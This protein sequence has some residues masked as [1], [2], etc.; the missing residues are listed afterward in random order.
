MINYSVCHPAWRSKPATCVA[1]TPTDARTP[2]CRCRRMAFVLSRGRRRC[3]EHREAPPHM[4]QLPLQQSLAL[5]IRCPLRVCAPRG[6][7]AGASRD[8]APHLG[9]TIMKQHL[10]MLVGKCVA[11]ILRSNAQIMKSPQS[12]GN[13][14]EQAGWTLAHHRQTHLGVRPSALLWTHRPSSGSDAKRPS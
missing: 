6:V 13:N 9:R 12:I 3:L 14:I 5:A 10:Q 4:S 7:C 11:M 8:R 2:H 1:D